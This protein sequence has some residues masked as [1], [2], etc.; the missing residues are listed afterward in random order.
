MCVF[1]WA[2]HLKMHTALK[3]VLDWCLNIRLVFLLVAF[4]QSLHTFFKINLNWKLLTRTPIKKQNYF[5]MNIRTMPKFQFE[6]V[7]ERFEKNDDFMPLN[8]TA[9]KGT[10]HKIFE[11]NNE[12]WQQNTAI[13]ISHLISKCND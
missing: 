9:K 5:Q 4:Q 2:L 10:H 8:S 11:S 13:F 1:F 6:S 12:Q 7:K 3:C